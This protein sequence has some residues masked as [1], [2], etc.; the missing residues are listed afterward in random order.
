MLYQQAHYSCT[1]SA[2]TAL[3]HH[4]VRAFVSELAKLAWWLVLLWVHL[5]GG[6]QAFPCALL[7]DWKVLVWGASL[8]TMP[9]SNSSSSSS[10]RIVMFVNTQHVLEVLDTGSQPIKRQKFWRG[11]LFCMSRL[12]RE[13]VNF[14]K[15][16]M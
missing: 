15:V 7:V 12:Q 13:S 10:K 6:F 2:F 14:V 16:V 9:D 8:V 4:A 5:A 11:V 1:A 3:L